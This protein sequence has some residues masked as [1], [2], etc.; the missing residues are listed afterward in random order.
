MEATSGRGVRPERPLSPHLQIYSPLI[1]MVMSILHRITGAAL[2]AGSLLLAWWLIA[3]ASG[4]DYYNYVL[5]WFATWPGKIILLG[6]T[7]VLMNHMLGGLR[8]FLW[9]TGHG[10]DL[11][12]IDILSWGSLAASFTLTAIIW[13]FAALGGI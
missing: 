13:A 11:K 5:S 8:H 7:W 4:P 6:Y 1:N 10:Y 3:A 9:D 2:Y 12:T